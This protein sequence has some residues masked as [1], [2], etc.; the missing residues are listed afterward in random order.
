M[1]HSTQLGEFALA[2][3]SS[4]RTV[5][6]LDLNLTLKGRGRFCRNYQVGVDTPFLGEVSYEEGIR[7]ANLLAEACPNLRSLGVGD[8]GVAVL[9]VFASRCQKLRKLNLACEDTGETTSG[10]YMRPSLHSSYDAKVK[11]QVFRQQLAYISTLNSFPGVTTLDMG[12]L[13]SCD[14]ASVW[15]VLPPGLEDLHCHDLPWELPKHLHLPTLT[16]VH[17]AQSPQHARH[18][19]QQH[20][21]A[22]SQLAKLLTTAP[23]LQTL[24]SS[25]TASATFRL[26]IAS[27]T[28]EEVAAIQTIHQR[29]DA[30]LWLGAIQIQCGAAFNF[31]LW[32]P[33]L[34]V[35]HALKTVLCLLP[36]MPLFLD[37]QLLASYEEHT[38][39]CLSHITRA[40]PSISALRLIGP[41][42]DADVQQLLGC[43]SL[44]SLDIQ[45]AECVSANV[46]QELL[47]VPSWL[48]YLRSP[49]EDLCV[50]DLQAKLLEA[51]QVQPVVEGEDP[52]RMG[53]WD[54]V[55]MVD[56]CMV[57]SRLPPC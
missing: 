5:E 13:G 54:Q 31:E 2:M 12:A 6:T 41:W 10:F 23:K 50:R 57:W 14:R 46:I 36:P 52:H 17:L 15:L 1:P 24:T 25:S 22:V 35:H 4:L 20:Y 42:K 55:V 27:C 43:T 11:E 26:N 44:R 39:D 8:V 40:F 18:G 47:C 28:L 53:K 30:G 38:S 56:R 37:I 3:R 7:I 19:A 48:T 49:S 34:E 29:L 32:E 51:E 21:T 45:S 33:E 16:R 9:K